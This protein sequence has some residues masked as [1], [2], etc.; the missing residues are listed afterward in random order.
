[1]ITVLSVAILYMIGYAAKERKQKEAFYGKWECGSKQ[2]NFKYYGCCRLQ[3]MFL[4]L[5][6]YHK[7]ETQGSVAYQLHLRDREKQT[8]TFDI[9]IKDEQLYLLDDVYERQR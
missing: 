5:V 9:L 4:Y 8:Y 3:D 1:M 7:V 2:L 6:K